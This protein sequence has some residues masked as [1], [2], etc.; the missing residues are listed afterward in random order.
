M[1]ERKRILR[2]MS[3]TE[4]HG[5]LADLFRALD[6]NYWVEVTHGSSEM[7]KDLVIVRRDPLTPDVIG[8]V[9]KCGDL[10]GKTAGDVDAL[11]KRVQGVFSARGD[12]IT[13]EIVSQIAQARSHE[14]VLKA[15]VQKLK[16]TK[17]IVVLVG[18]MSNNARTRLEE[19][20]GQSGQLYDLPWVVNSFTDHYPQVFFEGR[21]IDFLDTLIR[22]L[23][24]DSFYD[25]AGKTLSEC[26]VEPV[27]SQL[28]QH[29][30]V[31]DESLAVEIL[32]RRVR[33]SRLSEAASQKKRLLLVGDPGTG[34]SKAVSKLCID[35]YR[36]ALAQMTRAKTHT[37]PRPLP[38]VITGRRLQQIHSVPVLLDV[39]LPTQVRDRFVVGTLIVDG[40]DE[41]PE[42]ERQETLERGR[43][44]A[45][46]LEVALVI[47]SRKIAAFKAAP[48]GFA[49][50]EVLPFEIGQALRLVEKVMANAAVLP[51]LREGLQRI[52][53]QVPMS[54]LSLLLLV[55][56]V[57][58]RKEVPSSVT[59][60]YDRF[61]DLV[62]G[63]WDQDKGV[64]VLFEYLIKKRF[65][66]ALAYQEF[67]SKNRLEIP[68]SDFEKFIHE[69]AAQYGWDDSKLREFLREIERA[70]VIEVHEEVFFRHRS[71]LDYF[72]AL[73]VFDQRATFPDLTGAVKDFY[74][75]SV[76]SEVAFFY[77]GLGREIGPELLTAIFSHQE[78]GNS[79]PVDK[80]L[81]GR[82]LQAGWHSTAV[83]KEQGVR[84][85]I[86]YIPA[87]ADLSSEFFKQAGAG[88]PLLYSDM[89]A[90]FLAEWSLGSVFLSDEDL[91]ALVEL[92]RAN[93]TEFS[94]LLKRAA[95]LWVARRIL[96]P[97]DHEEHTERFLEH[98][99]KARLSTI[100]EARLLLL[101]AVSQPANA[102]LL[103]AVG[104]R[105]RRLTKDA[106][107]ALA[108]LVPARKKG[109]R[110]R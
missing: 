102:G 63:R 34:K 30:S 76:W 27:I 69:Y 13:A 61:L 74:F 84:Q 78:N 5:Y 99:Q 39:L 16:V 92:E 90:L 17:V 62:F 110:R 47:T 50:F 81:A 18:D 86:S 46:E 100:D 93:S 14:A 53:G 60:L 96:E 29:V 98:V 71:F 28:D 107:G 104:R 40:L 21:A 80:L 79:Y 97:K 38:F 103:K 94:E 15:Y 72:V 55:E 56:L 68:A 33:F 58:Q 25:K 66:S 82:L 54:P 91:A 32:N 64:E 48:P 88:A 9:V 22:G 89:M 109:F 65:L 36:S 35:S 87:T 105:L 83:V 26:F 67:R 2:T 108:R 57:S 73:Y 59:E 77:S 6:A 4:L 8:V 31:D 12:K 11:K 45:E 43:T 44:F 7:G 3:E 24:H 75:D 19:E 106:P 1:E 42:S 20:V 37:G 70:G 101:G 52:Q 85:V 10:K 49:R 41:V 23:E 95:L 51:A